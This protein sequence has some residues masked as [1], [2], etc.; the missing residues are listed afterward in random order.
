MHSKTLGPGSIGYY[1][2]TPVSAC[3]G[4]LQDPGCDP[5]PQFLWP[6]LDIML[7]TCT[8]SNP[9]TPAGKNACDALNVGGVNTMCGDD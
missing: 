1:W 9:N 2:N 7:L 4:W 6:T 3:P 5:M 8:G